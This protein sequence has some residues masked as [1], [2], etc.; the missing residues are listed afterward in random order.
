MGRRASYA[1]GVPC[2]I[3]RI[4][5]DLGGAQEFYSALFGWS[6]AD[7][8]AYRTAQLADGIIAGLGTAPT[9]LELW[10][11]YLA[12]KDVDATLADVQALGGTVVMAPMAAGDNGRL[13]LA[14]DPA[15]TPVGFWEGHRREGVVLVD[16]PGAVCR[17]ELRIP[18]ADAVR[19]FY[20]GLFGYDLVRRDGEITLDLDG[21]TQVRVVE[22]AAARPH[23]LVY[24]GVAELAPIVR[25]ALAAGAKL[26]EQS[27]DGSVVLRDPQGAAFGLCLI[28]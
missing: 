11:V 19:E 9:P 8:G 16:E 24:F 22:N 5:A 27:A 18:R 25:L 21:S 26:V 4:T 3:D 6:Y 15:G 7:E 20:A 2:W 23:W 12:T 28:G 13:F 10:T 17:Y 1:T 14:V